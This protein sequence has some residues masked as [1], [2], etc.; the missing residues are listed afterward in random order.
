MRQFWARGCLARGMFTEVEEGN[1][2][3]RAVIGF[4]QG[5]T[6]LQVSVSLDDLKCGVPKP[7]YEFDTSPDSG[8]KPGGV[9]FAAAAKYA[10]AGFD[11]EK[12][13][14]QTASAIAADVTQDRAPL[15]DLPKV[16]NSGLK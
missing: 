1:R 7:F 13:V 2:L 11:L 14:T 6:D 3:R 12:N 8:N 5:K 10:F 15:S 16:I 4:G 9:K